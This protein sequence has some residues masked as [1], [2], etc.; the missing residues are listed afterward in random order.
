MLSIVVPLLNEAESLGR[1]MRNWRPWPT[2]TATR[3]RSAGRRRLDRRFVAEICRLAALDP[4]V[5]GIRFR[6]NFG[7]AAALSRIPG[8]PRRADR[9]DGRRFARRPARDSSLLGTW[10]EGY[11]VVSGWK[12]VRH[13]PW[14]KVLPSRVFNWRS[15]G[16]RA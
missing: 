8:S 12:Q 14:H 16:S 11:D 15:V 2:A 4:R 3:W 13:D 7:K 5:R 6:R 9:H 1:S 10:T